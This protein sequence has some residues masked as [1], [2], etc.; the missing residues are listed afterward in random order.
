MSCR[1]VERAERAAD[2]SEPADPPKKQKVDVPEL[3]DN[4]QPFFYTSP[5]FLF[6]LRLL[7]LLRLSRPTIFTPQLARKKKGFLFCQPLRL[8]TRMKN[9]Q[10]TDTNTSVHNPATW[11]VRRGSQD[12]QDPQDPQKKKRP[13]HRGRRRAC[14]L[15][16]FCKGKTCYSTEKGSGGLPTPRK[17][18]DSPLVSPPFWRSL[19]PK[20][21]GILLGRLY[22]RGSPYLWPSSPPSAPFLEILLN[23]ILKCDK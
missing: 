9:V 7:R 6:C 2:E 14:F 23:T 22:L 11:P 4:E 16:N 8:C 5:P 15:S 3:S 13:F 18:V 10:A 12:P 20:R 19:L 17:G 21:K 1:S